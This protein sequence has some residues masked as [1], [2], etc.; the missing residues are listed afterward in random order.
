MFAI[1]DHRLNPT[2][3]LDL[4]AL[5]LEM[6]DFIIR[7]YP[8][9][10]SITGNGVRETL[11]AI[12][13]YVNLEI[14]EVPSGT[15]VLDWTVPPEWNIR[16]AYIKD[17]SGRK[18]LDFANSNLHVVGYS[19]PV[20]QKMSLE[21][22]K[23]HLFTLPDRPKAIPYRTSYYQKDWGFCLAHAQ[24]EQL[25]DGEYEVFI[26]STLEPGSLCYGE[27][28][29][30]GNL[31]EE[32]LISTHVCHP[33]L[34]N[35]NLSGIAVATFL[36]RSLAGR[37]RRYSYRFL[38]VPG[39]IG[40]ITWLAFNQS[41]TN[42]IR[43][44]MV[45]ACVG[46]DGPFTYKRSRQDKAEIDRIVS[47]VLATSGKEYEIRRFIPYGYDER[48][49][50]SPGFNLP[51]GCLM[52]TP[53]G[54]FEEYHNSDDDLNFVQAE[55]LAGSLHQCFRIVEV[56][57]RNHSFLNTAPYGEPQ[58]GKRG[59]YDGTEEQRHALLWVLNYSDG[60]H[61]LLDIAELSNLNFSMVAEA[62]DRL[63]ARGLLK[64]ADKKSL[65]S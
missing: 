1:S 47:H 14:R 30:P 60:S 15:R 44:G 59:L 48:Q 56:I 10:R 39:T 57:E 65:E 49:Y 52:R 33:S 36:A 7:L 32:V 23:P 40:P 43:Y 38:F 42:S 25:I 53:H 26:D 21:N 9:C 12:R 58:L 41:R 11:Q 28:Y 35:D 45:L 22:L 64:E 62:A 51:V 34:C 37:S 5:G 54:E 55:A 31:D 29:L 2:S 50:C 18:I 16:A 27:A 8:V 24:F 20:H 19:I 4:T 46:D 3:E 13:E 63:L 6:Y 61:S 17:P